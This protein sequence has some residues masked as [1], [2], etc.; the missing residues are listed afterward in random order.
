[1][2][3]PLELGIGFLTGRTNICNIINNCYKDMIKQLKD[4]P[5][6][7]NLTIFILYDLE[8]Q[9][10]KR[11]EFYSL[12]D[13]VYKKIHIKYITPE[14]IE[15]EKK[16]LKSRYNLTRYETNLVLGKGYGKARNAIMYFALKRNIDYLLFWDD[17][18]YPYAC[19]KGQNSEIIWEKQNNLVEH[20]N[21][22]KYSD[23]TIGHRCGNMSPVP[24]IEFGEDNI[25][26]QKFKEYIEA[27]S[28]EVITWEKVKKYMTVDKS[29]GMAFAERDITEGK[30][31]I[32]LKH[33]GLKNWLY[34]SGICINLTHIDRIP[35]FYNPPYARGEDT[36]FC[37][38]LT[39]AK[40]VKVPTYH[41][42]D[43]FLK[44][45]EIVRGK[46]PKEFE[47]VSLDDEAIGDRFL[48][49]SLGWIK[50]KPL[51][52]YIM[53]RTT[54]LT[55]IEIAKE[56]LRNSINNIN[57]IFPHSDFLSLLGELEKYDEDVQKHYK[58]YLKTNDV[59]NRIKNYISEQGKD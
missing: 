4:Y 1:M 52:M 56:K 37:T 5:D 13:D 12:K 34:A 9:N 38:L 46:F 28:N 6:E 3:K 22:I 20:L 43:S 57:E 55:D 25:K 16:I 21:V 32:V 44:Y 51:L 19:I 33:V 2:G 8:Y 15:E 58:E 42:H 17:D 40:V 54:Y 14:D 27:V 48:K 50:Y 41:F 30:D 49:A 53:Q 47:K 35:A 23:V 26:E 39:E 11:E 31:K 29:H 24:Y 18:E 45:P 7:V 10:T 59:W 36:F